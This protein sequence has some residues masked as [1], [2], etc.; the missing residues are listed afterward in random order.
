MQIIK[1]HKQDFDLKEKSLTMECDDETGT[2]VYTEIDF[3]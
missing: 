2:I 3:N 1:N